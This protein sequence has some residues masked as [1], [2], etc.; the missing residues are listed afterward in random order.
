MPLHQKRHT[1]T[2]MSPS[3]EQLAKLARLL[4]R[5][6]SFATFAYSQAPVG[7][8]LAVMSVFPL[9]SQYRPP[10][11]IA[12]SQPSRCSGN[13]ARLIP[14]YRTYLQGTLSG[15]CSQQMPSAAKVGTS[16]QAA[17]LLKRPQAKAAHALLSHGN[18]LNYRG[19]RAGGIYRV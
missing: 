3:S 19:C 7:G 16:L 2:W 18:V 15:P 12:L 5:R 6:Y 13:L 11:L 1:S 17:Q 4:S 8:R 9:P 14:K 10:M